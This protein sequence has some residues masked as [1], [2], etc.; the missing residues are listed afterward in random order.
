MANSLVDF[1][2]KDEEEIP[3]ALP[4]TATRP[5]VPWSAQ[6]IWSGAVGDASALSV[7]EEKPK[8]SVAKT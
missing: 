2:R 3:G 1:D 6:G 7:F 8:K 4:P 5:R